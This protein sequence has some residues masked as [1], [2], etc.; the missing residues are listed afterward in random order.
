M[1]QKKYVRKP[2]PVYPVI[3]FN[4]A[5]EAWFWYVRCQRLRDIGATLRDRTGTSARP[6]DPDDLYRAVIT[7]ARTGRISRTHLGVLGRFGIEDRPPDPRCAEEMGAARL[8][9]EALDRLTTVL[10]Q[11]GIVRLPDAMENGHL[12]PPDD[13]GKERGLPWP[14]EVPFREVPQPGAADPVSASL[15]PPGREAPR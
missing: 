7:L 9:D 1:Q 2:L 13:S 14:V 8:W 12:P 6:C 5:E 11:K 3:P 4:D 10:R 15:M